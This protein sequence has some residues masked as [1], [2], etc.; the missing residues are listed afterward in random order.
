MDKYRI[1]HNSKFKVTFDAGETVGVYGTAKE[2]QKTSN[3]FAQDDSVF[4]RRELW[5]KRRWT[6]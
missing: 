1:T 4:R 5:S 6:V 2:A 3:D